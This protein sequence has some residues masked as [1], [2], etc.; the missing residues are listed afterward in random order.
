MIDDHQIFK[1]FS[2]KCIFCDKTPQLKKGV[3]RRFF[4]TT[5]F[6]AKLNEL[7]YEGDSFS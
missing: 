6:Q 2:R 3:L 5:G 4:F 1:Y 7:E